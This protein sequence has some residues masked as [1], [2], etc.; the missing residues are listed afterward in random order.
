MTDQ[1]LPPKLIS[2][3]YYFVIVCFVFYITFATGYI[4]YHVTR[5]SYDV[6]SMTLKIGRLQDSVAEQR[7]M[8]EQAQTSIDDLK[9]ELKELK[10]G[11]P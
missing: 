5:L 4:K 6:F 7:K 2:S 3:K 9:R 10:R 8:L 11:E 1:T